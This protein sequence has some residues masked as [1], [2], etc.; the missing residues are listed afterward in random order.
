LI[1]AT[2]SFFLLLGEVQDCI[3]AP[4]GWQDAAG[5]GINGGCDVFEENGW[6]AFYGDSAFNPD[7]ISANGACCGCGGGRPA[8][9]CNA[10]GLLANAAATGDCV[11]ELIS[12]GSCSNIP[13]SGYT[14]TASTCVDGVLTA[15][16]CEG[17]THA[18][19]RG[20]D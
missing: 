10:S 11:V 20:C 8:L 9:P 7:G 4:V 18:I 15:G 13:I 5:D 14:C 2:L 19:K 16:A 1:L 3:D 12:G 17:T 6:C